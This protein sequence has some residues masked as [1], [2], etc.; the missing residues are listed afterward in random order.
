VFEPRKS[1]PLFDCRLY[2]RAD[3]PRQITAQFFAAAGRV[4]RVD[5]ERL[6]DQQQVLG[7]GRHPSTR[8]SVARKNARRKD[9]A[10]KRQIGSARTSTTNRPTVLPT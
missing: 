2:T 5:D 1:L 6:D 8:T 10:A 7:H 9:K 3:P 4:A